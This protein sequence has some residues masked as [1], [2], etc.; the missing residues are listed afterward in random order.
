[1]EE[2]KDNKLPIWAIVLIALG[3]FAVFLIIVVPLFFMGKRK[4]S[5][6]KLFSPK[7]RGFFGK[8]PAIKSPSRRSY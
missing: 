6:Q 7:K 4:N 1:M 3:V 8:S 2:E 5:F